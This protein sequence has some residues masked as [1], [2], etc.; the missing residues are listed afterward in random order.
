MADRKVPGYD[1]Q[2]DLVMMKLLDKCEQ[3]K[4]KLAAEIE[5]CAFQAD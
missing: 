1:S 4:S 2:C 3:A 5:V